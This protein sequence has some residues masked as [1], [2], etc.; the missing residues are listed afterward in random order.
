MDQVTQDL[1]VYDAFWRQDFTTA[2][3]VNEPF[4]PEG[5]QP[6]SI[7]GGHSNVRI[8]AGMTGPASGGRPSQS[9][10][11]GEGPQIQVARQEEGYHRTLGNQPPSSPSQPGLHPAW[12]EIEDPQ[13]THRGLQGRRA[14][15]RQPPAEL[16]PT[17][18][19]FPGLAATTSRQGLQEQQP[20]LYPLSAG[21]DPGWTGLETHEDI[22]PDIRQS[23]SASDL[24]NPLYGTFQGGLRAVRT[25]RTD[26][27]RQAPFSTGARVDAPRVQRV[28]EPRSSQR[29]QPRPVRDPMTGAVLSARRRASAQGS[30]EGDEEEDQ[31][32]QSK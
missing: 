9:S 7:R 13:A 6:R 3:S 8:T 22:V 19:D 27:S 17:W 12:R 23:R 2:P 30:D 11:A 25:P 14:P 31:M 29:V 24:G 15:S 1:M 10:V 32:E 20:P 16:P 18:V 21:P 5:L 28:P 4:A 26:T